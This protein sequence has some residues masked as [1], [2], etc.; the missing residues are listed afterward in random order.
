MTA[1]QTQLRRGTSAQVAAA[2][3]VVGEAVVNTTD[4][5]IHVGNGST[6]GG[7]PH[8]TFNDIQ[9]GTFT[10][11]TVGGTANA[12]TLTNTP[13]ISGY[14]NKLSLKFKAT[15]TNTGATTV[16]VDGKGAKNIYKISGTSLVALTGGEIVSGG[17]YEINY[18]G[19]QFLLGAGSGGQSMTVNVQT[20]STSGTYTPTSNMKYC[21]VELKGGGGGGGGTGI[22]LNG[23]A[24][25]GGGEGG[26]CIRVYDAATIGSSQSVTIG[27]GG[28]SNTAGGSSTFMTMTAGGGAAGGTTSASARGGAGGTATGGTVNIPGACGHGSYGTSTGYSGAGGGPGGGVAVTTAGSA[29]NNG[30]GPGAGGSGGMAAGSSISG[31]SGSAGICII[32]EWCQ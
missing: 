29:G 2:T 10:N 17:I 31:G 6:A 22:L 20:F 8:A 7:I 25:G 16:N 15:N 19:T 3:P 32:T 12:I 1:T 18:D 26:T 28:A 21:Q 9:F 24:G 27:A 23:N 13:P 11:G 30:T 14:A 5:R 4:S